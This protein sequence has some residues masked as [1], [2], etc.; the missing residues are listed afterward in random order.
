[1]LGGR[2]FGPADW[3]GH[4]AQGEGIEGLEGAIVKKSS[5][6]VVNP[7]H[8]NS[9]ETPMDLW[10]EGAWMGSERVWGKNQSNYMIWSNSSVIESHFAMPSV[11]LPIVG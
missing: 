5:D 2:V 9:G 7:W 10:L 4:D 1:M 3:P 8:G 11:Y 6:I